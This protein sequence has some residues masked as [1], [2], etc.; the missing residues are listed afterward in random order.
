MIAALALVILILT[1]IGHHIVP[2][3]PSGL[4]LVVE[5]TPTKHHKNNVEKH[6][7]MEIGGLGLFPTEAADTVKDIYRVGYLSLEDPLVLQA[8]LS[9]LP[10]NLVGVLSSSVHE[11]SLAIIEQ[12]KRQR[13][14]IQ[15]DELTEHNAVIVKIFPDRIILNQQGYYKSLLLNEH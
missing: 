14:Y 9:H 1:R 6:N 5:K 11:N 7:I 3:W 2:L 13:S 15:G 12:N 8:P 10:L 4:P